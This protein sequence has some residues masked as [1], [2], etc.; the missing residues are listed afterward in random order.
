VSDHDLTCDEAEALLPLV[1][2][3]VLD[4]T[5]DPV[6]FQ[7]LAHC[8]RCQESLTQH[9]LVTFALTRPAPPMLVLKPAVPRRRG[10]S[11]A[12]AALFAVGLGLAIEAGA[13]PSAAGI[14]APTNPAVASIPPAV[15]T[16]ATAQP[17]PDAAQP[18]DVEV[19]T[20]PGSTARHPHY[21]VR[22]GDQVMLVDPA[23]R[24]DQTPPPEAQAASLR[25]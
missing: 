19:V 18:I 12:A 6:L 16:Q 7:H 11:L 21:L 8:T 5:T 25:Y 1:A 13:H 4:A 23:E 22:H 9:D 15:P 3:G 20:V 17:L 2:D 24:E 10:W 14:P